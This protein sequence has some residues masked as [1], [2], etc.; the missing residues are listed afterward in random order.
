MILP[1]RQRLQE[2]LANGSKA[3]AALASYMLA[4]MSSVPF[5]TAASVAEKVSVS[6]ATVG[7]FCRSLGYKSLKGLKQHL[8]QD[9]GDQPWLIS[10]RLREFLD[11]NLSGEDQLASSLQLEISGLVAIYELAH[12]EE[13]KRAVKR[14]STASAVFVTGFQTERGIAQYLANNLQYLRDGVQLV[15]LADGNFAQVLMTES[16][17]PC[18]VLFEARRHS[19]MAQQLAQ[20]AKDAGVATTLVTDA[21]CDWGHDLVD[22]MFV[23]STEFSLF[24]DST[25]QMASLSSLLVNNVFIELGQSVEERMN[26]VAA[27]YNRFTGHVGGG[28]APAAL[29][30]AANG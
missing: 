17:S 9:L 7:R 28:P 1:L 16:P 25:A 6:E 21:F 18:L 4:Q 14:I 2:R 13:W 29:P 19:R 22:E 23:V 27:L 15:D 24:W 20:E 10:D 3:D 26:K 11:R 30:T 8:R 12:S 5:E